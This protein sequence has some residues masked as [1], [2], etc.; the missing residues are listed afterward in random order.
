MKM[1]DLLKN[2]AQKRII[3]LTDF[4][5]SQFISKNNPIVMLASACVS[6]ENKNGH[7]FLPLE[8]FE[9]KMFFFY[10]K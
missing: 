4:Y 9:K 5:F 3:G 2:L 10:F 8:Y 6:Y 7:I 1:T